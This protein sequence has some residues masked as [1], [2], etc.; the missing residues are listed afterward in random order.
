MKDNLI[1]GHAIW[2]KPGLDNETSAVVKSKAT[3]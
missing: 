1:S 3:P 2:S